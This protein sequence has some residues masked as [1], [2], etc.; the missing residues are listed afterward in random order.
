MTT[1]KGVKAEEKFYADI[2]DNA[3]FREFLS[4]TGF[5]LFQNDERL[6]ASGW[7]NEQILSIYFNNVSVEAGKKYDFFHDSESSV[8]AAFVGLN[9]Q[10][11]S[12]TGSVEVISYQFKKHFKATFDF[13]IDAVGE[14]RT[15]K[16]IGGVSL[17]AE[18]LSTAS[19]PD[20]DVFKHLKKLAGLK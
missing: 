11:S 19:A 14:N 3:G 1:S 17:G 2:T 18:D 16:F 9:G 10:W 20:I 4:A 6:Q 5:S 15:F 8:G 12:Y 7:H 13:T